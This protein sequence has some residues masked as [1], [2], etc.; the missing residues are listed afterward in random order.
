MCRGKIAR[1]NR[2][3]I[4]RLFV[5][6]DVTEIRESVYLAGQKCERGSAGKCDINFS[7]PG[8]AGTT[9]LLQI[10]SSPLANYYLPRAPS[11][12]SRISAALP[13]HLISQ[14]RAYGSLQT[15]CVKSPQACSRYLFLD[16]NS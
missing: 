12:V 3:R 16:K 4:P 6:Q 9:A 5:K 10:P 13:D 8:N 15:L 1:G 2:A 11:S 14:T 7:V